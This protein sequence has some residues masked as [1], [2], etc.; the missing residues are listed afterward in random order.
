MKT[1]ILNLKKQ[2]KFLS[3]TII[4]I[5]VLYV[6]LRFSCSSSYLSTIKVI[7]SNLENLNYQK[8][9]QDFFSSTFS[10]PIDMNEL[11]NFNKG[12]L[13]YE[14]FVSKMKD[15]FSKIDNDFL[16][17][18]LISRK[19]NLPEGYL[20]IS[21]GIDGKL[22]T[23]IEGALYFDE[24]NSL[25]LYN[26]PVMS[27]DLS[28]QEIESE[29]KLSHCLFG[30]KDLLIEYINGINVFISNAIQNKH[31]PSSLFEKV[32]KKRR[33]KKMD[34]SVMGRGINIGA[35]RIVI[36]DDNQN[37]ICNM[38]EGKEYN[39]TD[40]KQIEIVGSFRN[41]IDEATNSVFLDNCILLEDN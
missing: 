12:A 39:F 8:A 20:L 25:L 11:Y 5:V 7:T 36:Q 9:F 22:N 41:R 34:C 2:N 10:Y 35:G 32:N 19:N 30:K 26:N 15:P 24:V 21:A 14:E 31:T 28:Y 29:F 38:Y 16:Y 27:N 6:G 18:P 37:V 17:V 23:K 33:L 13:R 3:V 4:L 40:G 1:K